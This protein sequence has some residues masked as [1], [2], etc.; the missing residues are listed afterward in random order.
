[1][2]HDQTKILEELKLQ[3]KHIMPPDPTAH[4]WPHIYRVLKLA[5]DIA[6]QEG[7]DAFMVSLIALT[8]D[9]YD[10][11][12]FKGSEEEAKIS[13]TNDLLQLKVEKSI[14][15]KVVTQVFSLSYSKADRWKNLNHE[16]KIVQD[17]DRIEAIGAIGIARAFA[18]GG[19]KGRVMCTEVLEDS[20][21][22][23]P[24][25]REPNTFDH[26]DEKLLKL[27]DLLNTTTAKQ[28][29]HD[30]FNFMVDFVKRFKE[31]WYG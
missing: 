21:T 4:D 8:H 19:Y 30:R 26:F 1:M 14:A 28:I 27:F 2:E 20:L 5:L 11:K 3:V 23:A 25:S 10:H 17:A 24:F 9:L 12:F 6:Q 18:F 29:A 31:E 22:A 7:G 16:G 13:L 15:D